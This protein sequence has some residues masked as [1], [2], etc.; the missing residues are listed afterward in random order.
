[1]FF[2]CIFTGINALPQAI[3]KPPKVKRCAGTPNCS[4]ANIAT[5]TAV[6]ALRAMCTRDG[7]WGAA[8]SV[9]VLWRILPPGLYKCR[10][11]VAGRG[12]Y[13]G[14]GRLWTEMPRHGRF[15]NGTDLEYFVLK[16]PTITTRLNRL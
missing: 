1:M 2:F 10:V 3:S 4:R 14:G 5:P 7:R 6:C 12:V 9:H 8:A 13:T 16:L 11:K 15:A